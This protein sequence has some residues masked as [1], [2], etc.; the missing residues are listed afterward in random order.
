VRHRLGLAT[1]TPNIHATSTFNH[2]FSQSSIHPF[3]HSFTHSLTHPLAQSSNKY[4]SLQ[5]TTSVQ[6]PRPCCR[7]RC[8]L[9]TVERLFVGDLRT[10]CGLEDTE[11]ADNKADK[12]TTSEGISL[13]LVMK[14]CLT[15][16]TTNSDIMTSIMSGTSTQKCSTTTS[17]TF[18]ASANQLM[19]HSFWLQK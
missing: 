19:R 2:L 15:Q 16:S 1:R 18:T 5:R 8:I 11:W 3:N 17:T 13:N 14:A 4:S 6:F 7:S 9:R 10:H 12:V